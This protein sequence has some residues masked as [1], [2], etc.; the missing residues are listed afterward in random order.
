MTKQSEKDLQKMVC[1]YLKTAYPNVIFNSDMAGIRL[2]WG[3]AK[4]AKNLRSHNG[5]PDL[6]I[7]EYRKGYNGLFLELKAEGQK[8]TKK[9]GS[10]VSEH[11]KEQNYIIEQL[12][13]RGYYATFAI[14]FAAARN[15]I[16]W[17][18]GKPF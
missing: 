6:A 2:T 14:G 13:K 3:Q 10:F 16:D 8:I 17:Y 4:E 11:V 1:E 5:F 7:Y 9:D 18:L 15:F 12:K